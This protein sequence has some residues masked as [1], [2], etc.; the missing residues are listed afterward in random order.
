MCRPISHS[1]AKLTGGQHSDSCLQEL[2]AFTTPTGFVTEKPCL[3]QGHTQ[4]IALVH[5]GSQ[6][7]F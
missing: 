5:M 3:P 6:L 4:L 1:K 2:G 7:G